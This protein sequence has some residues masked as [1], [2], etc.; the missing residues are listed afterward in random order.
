MLQ[1]AFAGYDGAVQFLGVVTKDNPERA[2][3]FLQEIGVTYPQ[4]VD[5]AGALLAH[6]RIA[7]L[8]VTVVLD[9]EGGVVGKVVGPVDEERLKQLLDSAA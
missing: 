1:S 6:L 7:G 4:V 8:P 5:P 9:A 3:S 2:G